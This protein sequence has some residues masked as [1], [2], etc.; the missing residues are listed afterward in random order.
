MTIGSV[1]YADIIGLTDADVEGSLVIS[2]G[3]VGV[4][5]EL[6]RV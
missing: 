1:R 6:V 2:L 5:H 3:I 4:G